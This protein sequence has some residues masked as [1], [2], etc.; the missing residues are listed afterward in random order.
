MLMSG[1]AGHLLCWVFAGQ[2]PDN[3]PVANGDAAPKGLRDI[4][5]AE[6]RRTELLLRETLRGLLRNYAIARDSTAQRGEQY[7]DKIVAT[8]ADAVPILLDFLRN[9][10]TSGGM[11][12]SFAGPI[13]RALARVF[14]SDP[15]HNI[16]ILQSLQQIAST[17]SSTVR[18]GV[19][20]GMQSL[21]HPMVLGIVG[22]MLKE[23]DNELRVQVVR[24]LGKQK[25]SAEMA[26]NQLR[27]LLSEE[28]APWAEVL[29]AMLALGDKRGVDF[30]QGSLAKS[31]DTT[32]LGVSTLY[33][34]ELG[35]RTAVAPLQKLVMH[36]PANL[37]DALL[38]KAIE[39][40][41]TIGL[42]EDDAHQP[43][44]AALVEIFKRHSSN[45]VKETARWELG[46]FQN[47]EALKS[48]EEGVQDNIKANVK[49]GRPNNPELF[50]ELAADRLQFE[51]WSKALQALD[52]AQQE[53]DKGFRTSQIEPM[54]AAAY[55]G[56]GKLEKSKKILLG[57]SMDDRIDLLGRYPVLEKMAKDPKYRDLFAQH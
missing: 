9:V 46:P 3:A 47:E 5:A 11:D 1:I 13:A 34:G 4:A 52:K 39:A 49:S 28:G 27:P 32:L 37:P 2:S 17:G 25:S 33:L 45:V 36:G 12:A 48:L 23:Q 26:G 44:E 19:L 42:R 24:V 38:K 20:E 55:C 18:G 53:D 43:A 8:G 50:L 22:P 14:D 21:D 41:R 54:R 30:A 31:N 16:Q 57:M 51:Q 6:A 7:L 15:K 29:N 40:I 10:G 56:D 35:G